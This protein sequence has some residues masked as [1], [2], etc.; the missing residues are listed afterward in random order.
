M[1]ARAADPM[2]SLEVFREQARGTPRETPLLFVHGAWH[3][4]W[5]WQEHFLPYF[6]ELGYDCW[7]FSFRAHGGSEGRERLRWCSLA[8]YVED[9]LAIARRMPRQ[10]VVIGHSMG[11]FVVQKFIQRHAVAGAV[12]LASVPPTWGAIPSAVR[13]VRR[14][15]LEFLKVQLKLSLYPL[16]E[17]PSLARDALFSDAMPE[18]Q[19]RTYWSKLQD[20]SY[21]AFVGMLGLELPKL[22]AGRTPMLVLGG[23]KDRV[24]STADVHHTARKYQAQLQVFDGMAHDLM[25]D[26]GWEK[27]AARIASWLDELQPR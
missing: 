9:T 18:E 15:P 22:T 21:R 27:V 13:T 5:C 20:E 16:I 19:A 8:E 1:A 12:L 3:A 24:I 11:G 6:A 4:A 7:A 25:L 2:P 23:A 26:L 10:P 14:H 17:T